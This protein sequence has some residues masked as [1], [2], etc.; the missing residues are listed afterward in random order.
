[1]LDDKIF[2]S[3]RGLVHEGKV[4]DPGKRRQFFP[5]RVQ[6]AFDI[7]ALR[8]NHHAIRRIQHPTA[9]VET[10][11][12]PV[13]KRSEANALHDAADFNPFANEFHLLEL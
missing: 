10:F 8:L 2:V 7:Q 13:D 1:M 4:I 12:D 3:A 6:E 9:D 5:Q 11:R